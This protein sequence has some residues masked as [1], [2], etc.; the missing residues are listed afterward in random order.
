[1]TYTTIIPH[2]DNIG[3]ERFINLPEEAQLECCTEGS[4][5]PELPI[6]LILHWSLEQADSAGGY[7]EAR[8]QEAL[9]QGAVNGLRPLPM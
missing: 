6:V 9:S 4:L 5:S 3:P 2:R 7:E 1:M 8:A